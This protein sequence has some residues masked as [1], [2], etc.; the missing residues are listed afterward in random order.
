[1]VY[2]LMRASFELIVFWQAHSQD[3]AYCEMKLN[4][5]NFKVFG[6]SLKVLRDLIS[7]EETQLFVSANTC[8]LSVEI[9][10]YGLVKSLG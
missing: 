2:R 8:W 4:G 9:V 5:Y 10:R 6:V 1:M 7:S 3:V